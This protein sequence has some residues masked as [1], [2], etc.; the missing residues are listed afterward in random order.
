VKPSKVEDK[1]D[2]Q[3][4]NK[5][6]EPAVDFRQ[7]FT[8][9]RNFSTR[10]QMQ[11]W[12]CGEAKKLGFVAVVVKSDNGGN[13][14]KAFVVMGCQRGDAHKAYINKKQEAAE[15]LKCNCPFKV[16]TYFLS[17]GEW[18]VSVI[19][20]THNHI[21]ANRLEGH[22]YAKQLIPE[23]VALVREM[24]KNNAPPRNI[25]STIRNKNSTSATTIKHIYNAHQRVR[26][27][28][29]RERTEMQQLFKCLSDGKYT[30]NT[31]L[32]SDNQTIS[33]IFF[34][35]P[36]LIKLFKLFPIVIL[37]DSTYKTNKYK[38]P[39]LEFVG[40]TS[41]EQ[42][43]TIGFTFVTSEKEDNF[44]WALERCH[45]LLKCRDH[46]NVVV[47]EQDVA[48]M[49]VVDRVFP[50]Y[51]ALLCRFHASMNVKSNMKEKCSV[52]EGSEVYEDIMGGL[53]EH[54]GLKNREVVCGFCL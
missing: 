54:T 6:V 17:S 40:T 33:H 4:N 52:E 29:R 36:E 28:D 48:L 22:K 20:G 32:L 24:S 41:T 46:S 19:D 11:D 30:C 26:K 51:T 27:A 5:P 16:R 45:E 15:T 47:F 38:F 13:K 42:T 8:M 23:K 9:V 44:V 3:S 21:M 25:S 37:M 53:G 31:R 49:N 10:Q 12:V 43:L 2:E 35:H 7:Q 18:T 1:I 39:L 50:K 34:S 14:K